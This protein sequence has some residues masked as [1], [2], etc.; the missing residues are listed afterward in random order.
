MKEIVKTEK[1]KHAS[2]TYV[3]HCP[4]CGCEV[5]FSEDD[6]YGNYLKDDTFKTY[7]IC[8]QYKN[9]IEL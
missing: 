9:E 6:C 1:A 8:P 7:I 5:W 2:V 3:T 4:N